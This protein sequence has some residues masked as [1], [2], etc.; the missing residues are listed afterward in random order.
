MCVCVCVCV[1]SLCVCMQHQ[2]EHICLGQLRNINKVSIVKYCTITDAL[3]DK[4]RL[5]RSIGCV[6]EISTDEVIIRDD[7]MK[8]NCT[9]SQKFLGM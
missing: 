7:S 9:A 4:S 6:N 2:T 1:L 3:E 5:N 8:L